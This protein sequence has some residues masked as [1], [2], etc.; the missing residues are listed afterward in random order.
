MDLTGLLTAVQAGNM[1][2]W[3]ASIHNPSESFNLSKYTAFYA[4][5]CSFIHFPCIPAAREMRRSSRCSFRRK[6]IWKT[7]LHTPGS[8]SLRRLQEELKN[9]ELRISR[10]KLPWALWYQCVIFLQKMLRTQAHDRLAV[11]RSTGHISRQS[12]L[13]SETVECVASFGKGFLGSAVLTRHSTFMLVHKHTLNW[14]SASR[15]ESLWTYTPC[16]ETCLLTP[17]CKAL[18]NQESTH[19]GWR[20]SWSPSLWEPLRCSYASWLAVWN[21]LRNRVGAVQFESF[22]SHASSSEKRKSRPAQHDSHT[23]HCGSFRQVLQSPRYCRGWWKIGLSRETMDDEPEPEDGNVDLRQTWRKEEKMFQQ[24]KVEYSRYEIWNS[25]QTQ[26]PFVPLNWDSFVI[27]TSFGYS[28]CHHSCLGLTAALVH[29]R[30]GGPGSDSNL[31]KLGLDRS[32][33]SIQCKPR[34]KR[35]MNLEWANGQLMGLA[36]VRRQQDDERKW[37]WDKQRRPFL[38]KALQVLKP[39]TATELQK[40]IQSSID[41]AGWECCAVAPTKGG[42]DCPRRTGENRTL[43]WVVCRESSLLSLL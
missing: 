17:Y 8:W 19:R 5:S 2:A 6:P 37:D 41:L 15:N 22:H 36:V 30:A 3:L 26:T 39:E 13:K 20:V 29:A 1:E 24:R 21:Y 31:C 35:L 28:Q 23:T 11:R 33:S 16:E 42:V 38:W 32:A 9:H 4:F 14:N 25:P 12:R 18:K 34:M 43:T 27:S 7:G 40:L 10:P